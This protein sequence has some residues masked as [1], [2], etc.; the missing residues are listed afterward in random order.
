MKSFLTFVTVLIMLTGCNEKKP[1]VPDQVQKALSRDYADAQD[2]EWTDKEKG[3]EVDFQQ[4][5]NNLEVEYNKEGEKLEEEIIIDP[6]E[7]PQSIRDY[8]RQEYS[9]LHI[10]EASLES[11]NDATVYEVELLNGFFREIDLEFDVDGNLL[12]KET[13]KE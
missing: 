5:E 3:Y 11:K 8:L 13:F 4:G 12:K 10:G 7:L 1:Q 6:E 2:V 9:Q